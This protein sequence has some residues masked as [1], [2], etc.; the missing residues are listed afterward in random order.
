[1]GEVLKL[2]RGDL[3]DALI[4]YALQAARDGHIEVMSL[5]QAA[6]DLGVSSGAVYRHF[7]DKDSLLMEIVKIG[8]FDLRDR[9]LKIRPEGDVAKTVEQAVERVFSLARIYIHYA[10]E[11]NA[12]WH[13]M[14]G[15][16]GMMCRDQLMQD[17]ELRR[18]TPFDLSSEVV[19]DLHRLGLLAKEPTI[20]DIRYMWSATH[21]A[22]DL[23]QSGARLDFEQL[24]QVVNDTVRRNMLS[25]GLDLDTL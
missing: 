10:H 4:T 7:D 5:R 14:F 20:A 25:I 13:M 2:K 22:A 1:M 18:Y 11:N 6:R 19:L 15:R 9:F 21:G 24:D 8:I 17:D 3:R 16:V 12:L 23:A